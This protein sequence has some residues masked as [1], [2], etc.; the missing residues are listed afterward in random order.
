MSDETQDL[1]EMLGFLGEDG[2]QRRDPEEHPSPEELS[3]Y[4]ANEL[5]R[6]EDEKIQDHLAVC[7]HCTELLLDLEEFLAPP[8]IA[9]EPA[10]FEAA[11]D[12]KRLREGMGPVAGK[13]EPLRTKAPERDYQLVRSLQMYRAL[14]AVLGLVVAGLSL[15]VVRPPGEPEILPPP[16]SINFETTRSS[17]AVE[18]LKV[19]LPFSLGF[20]SAPSYPS[21]RIEIVDVEGK[22]RY[23]R[24]TILSE[25]L[26]PL[27]Q[28]FLPP[29][30][31]KVRFSGLKDGKFEPIG[32]P[33]KVIIQP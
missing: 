13:P 12:W 21:Y 33:G 2:R 3:A 6:E 4:Q 18:P 25:G 7:Q 10:D 31:Y 30:E 32:R 22:L 28:G 20:Y 24:D 29:G 14:A 17:S 9:A 23:S 11:T 26:I 16:K 1:D 8:V 27:P 5:T 15:Y 19:R